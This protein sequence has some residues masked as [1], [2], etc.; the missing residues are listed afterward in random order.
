MKRSIVY[1]VLAC[2]FFDS[3][4]GISQNLI[5]E[6]FYN[7]LQGESVVSKVPKDID[8]TILRKT[9][10]HYA[11]F[12]Y[13]SFGDSIVFTYVPEVGFYG[14]DEFQVVYFEYNEGRTELIKKTKKVQIKVS[15]FR[16]NVDAF[17]VYS[18]QNHVLLDVLANDE[19]DSDVRLK[20][21]PIQPNSQLV[22]SNDS[23]SLEYNGSLKPIVESLLYSACDAN[24]H[25]ETGSLKLIVLDTTNQNTTISQKFLLKNATL[26]F[27][28]PYDDLAILNPTSHGLTSLDGYQLT[29][30]PNQDFVGWDTLTLVSNLGKIHNIHFKILDAN[31]PNVL[32]KD[33]YFF[34]LTNKRVIC[35]VL[36]NDF[37]SD[38]AVTVIDQ[39]EHGNLVSLTNGNFY[40][41]P[42]NG[43]QGVDA[44]IYSACET[45]TNV[46]ETGVAYISIGNFAPDYS[47]RLSTGKNHPL[48]ISYPFPVDGYNV[49]ILNVPQ[50][51]LAYPPSSDKSVLYVPSNEFVGSDSLRLQYCLVSAPYT[52][53]TVNV[54]INVLDVYTACTSK[55]V[56][57]GD[58]NNDGIVNMRDLL[59]LGPNIG[60]AGTARSNT[61]ND[62]WVGQACE[63]WRKVINKVDLK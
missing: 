60:N 51:G 9:P 41:L 25:C 21:L 1:F 14:Y 38:L 27:D 7:I 43:Y 63:D 45:Q 33:D 34:T 42:Q 32:V 57:P 20:F 3:Q 13:N 47:S 11:E 50:H 6:E 36:K 26:T 54:I 39:P 49:S 17:T 12:N 22:L 55:C 40:Y 31:P 35:E 10:S 61:I 15:R 58:N 4:L 16:L 46:C 59:F 23:L 19:V 5:Q 44:F 62:V 52:C 18:D 30:T 56:W 8:S 2:L 48:S 28:Y 29:Y 24:G 53:Y 37:T